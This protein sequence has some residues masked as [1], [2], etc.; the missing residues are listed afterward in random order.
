MFTDEPFNVINKEATCI[1]IAVAVFT[2]VLFTIY[3]S[4]TSF[5]TNL[6]HNKKHYRFSVQCSTTF[7]Y[8][9]YM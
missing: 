8:T 9:W 2:V 7:L 1:S 5:H 3:Q 6:N 4:C